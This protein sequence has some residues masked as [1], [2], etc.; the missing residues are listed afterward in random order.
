MQSHGKHMQDILSWETREEWEDLA[1]RGFY[2]AGGGED[3]HCKGPQRAQEV[4][5]PEPP[6]PCSTRQ[7]HG[8]SLAGLV[9]AETPPGLGAAL[10]CTWDT[11]LAWAMPGCLVDGPGGPRL[12]HPCSPTSAVQG[13]HA[14]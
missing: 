12:S 1:H 9:A 6:H 4:K 13:G 8:E 10:C 5:L 3:Q 7:L 2:A 11:Q 14:V